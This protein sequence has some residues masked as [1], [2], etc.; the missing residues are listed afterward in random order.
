MRGLSTSSDEASSDPGPANDSGTKDPAAKILAGAMRHVESLGFTVEAMQKAAEEL[1]YSR[2]VANMFP[3]AEA[4]L[5]EH[6][7][8]SARAETNA[9]LESMREE[10]AAMRVRDRVATGVRLRLKQLAPYV[11]TWPRAMYILSQPQNAAR[12]LHE[13]HLIVDDIWHAAGDTSVDMNWYSKRLLLAGCYTSSELFMLTDASPDFEE[14]YH[15]VDRAL[16]RVLRAGKAGSD[17][18]KWLENVGHSGASKPP[19]TKV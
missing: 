19:N 2:A 6:F 11:H 3:R 7:L 4:E 18:I 16:D 5:I 9:E 13:L 17:V 14:T 15:Y 10:L 8:E 1:G 12:S